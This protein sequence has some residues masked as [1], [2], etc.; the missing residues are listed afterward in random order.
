MGT[1]PPDTVQ[2][3]E[4]TVPPATVKYKERTVSPD[5]VQYKKPVAVRTVQQNAASQL[6]YRT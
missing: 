2:Y 5:T 6:R 3:K 4:R 1:V